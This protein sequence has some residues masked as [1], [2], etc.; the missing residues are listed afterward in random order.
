MDFYLYFSYLLS[1]S[2]EIPYKQAERDVFCDL[3]EN[4]L[5]EGLTFLA[6]VSKMTKQRDCVAECATCGLVHSSNCDVRS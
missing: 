1:G 3:C 4:R 6:S 2:A 5:R